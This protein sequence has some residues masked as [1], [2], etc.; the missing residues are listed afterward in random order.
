MTKE[1]MESAAERS[2]SQQ[3]LNMAVSSFETL[4]ALLG[5]TAYIEP[6][7]RARSAAAKLPAFTLDQV[8]EHCWVDDC[9]VVLYDR[10]YDV[11]RFLDVHPAGA[12]ILLESAGRDATSAF[13]GVG[14]SQQ[15]VDALLQY[16]VGVLVDAE[17]MWPA[18]K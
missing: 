13:R 17:C 11:T 6:A 5:L 12:D 7:L 18:S 4:S 2:S 16:Q 3:V 8:S 14:H 10:V 9:W 1:I 15:A